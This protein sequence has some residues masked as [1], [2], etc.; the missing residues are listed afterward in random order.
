ML[1]VRSIIIKTVLILPPPPPRGGSCE[2]GLGLAFFCNLIN[3]MM[4]NDTIARAA[5]LMFPPLEGVGGGDYNPNTQ[6]Y[7]V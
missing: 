3:S 6:Y 1:L 5:P 4:I 2:A 7:K